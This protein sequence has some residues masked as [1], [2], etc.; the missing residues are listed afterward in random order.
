[1]SS[2]VSFLLQIVG[3][4]CTGLSAYILVIKHK[5]V[6][7]PIDFFFDPSCILCTAGAITL[8]ITFFGW[9]GALR[10]YTCMLR[11]VGISSNLVTQIQHNNKYLQHA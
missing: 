6:R 2:F 8:V 4:A 10:E 7:D 9:M 3:L 5:V 1:M 11:T